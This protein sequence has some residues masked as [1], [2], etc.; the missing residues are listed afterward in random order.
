MG[1]LADRPGAPASSWRAPASSA[2]P[3]SSIWSASAAC[4][5]VGQAG[6]GSRITVHAT[7][8]GPR[9]ATAI[10]EPVIDGTVAA[11]H[12]GASPLTAAEAAAA[13]H[14]ACPE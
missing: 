3:V 9:H 8:R 2:R 7:P 10:S 11:F 14:P 12:A 4:F 13:L 6:F 5:I 1:A